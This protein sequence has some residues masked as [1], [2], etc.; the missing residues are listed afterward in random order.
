MKHYV[1]RWHKK[2][3]SLMNSLPGRELDTK[4]LLWRICTI[5]LNVKPPI[6][7]TRHKILQQIRFFLDSLSHYLIRNAAAFRGWRPVPC[8][9]SCQYR[10]SI[11]LA[12]HYLWMVLIFSGWLSAFFPHQLKGRHEGC[13]W[14]PRPPNCAFTRVCAN[15]KK[16][17]KVQSAQKLIYQLSAKHGVQL[18]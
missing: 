11:C 13:L 7:W 14:G 2:V 6:Q 3:V 9:T 15:E 12:F 4:H 1:N 18:L 10:A 17:Y 5:E 16:I 8:I